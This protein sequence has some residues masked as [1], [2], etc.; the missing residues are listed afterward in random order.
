MRKMSLFLWIISL[1]LLCVKLNAAYGDYQL[2][3]M[4]GSYGSGEGQFYQP[5]GIAVDADRYVYVAD[6][7]NS[8]I[9]KFDSSGSFIATWGSYGTGNGQFSGPRRVATDA[10]GYI[11]VVDL[12]TGDYIGEAIYRIQKFDSSGSF[13]ATWGSYGTGNGQFDFPSGI[14]VDADGY[15]YVADT[16]NSRIQKFDSWGTFIT[17]WGGTL[18]GYCGTGNGQFCHPFGIAVDADGYVYVTDSWNHRIQKFDSSGTFVTKWGSLGSGEGQFAY[19]LGIAVDADG[20]VYVADTNN[21]RIQK[22]T[23][24]GTFLTLWGDC[25]NEYL[26]PP[27]DVA[28]DADGYVYVANGGYNRIEKYAESESCAVSAIFGTETENVNLIRNLRDKILVSTRE[29]E[30]YVRLFYEHS[31]E[32]VAIMECNPA[33]KETA[34]TLL[35]TLLPDILSRLLGNRVTVAP[36]VMAEIEKLCD[37]LS[38]KAS[39]SLQKDINKA[40]ADIKNG[41]LLKKFGVDVTKPKTR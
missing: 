3:T 18:P 2:V 6:E 25:V 41:E 11:Y 31:S 23:S 39:P 28:V 14:A 9:Q 17:K 34:Y 32:I 35:H 22:F 30:E 7:G 37:V 26:Y 16:Y 19:P 33:I 8:R 40:K 4:W 10:D 1:A 27:Y 21:C 24:S 20:Y 15:V 5:F 13:I 12:D 36:G 38:N 29:G